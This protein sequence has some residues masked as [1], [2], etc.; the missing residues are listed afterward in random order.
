VRIGVFVAAALASSFLSAQ[1]PA[2]DLSVGDQAPPL[3]VSRWVKGERIERFEPGKV[4]VLDF[5]A[6]WCGPCIEAFPRLTRLQEKYA[7][8]GV[9]VV[10]VSIWEKDQPLVA[11]FVKARGDAMGFRVA[12]DDVPSG[13]AEAEE[14]GGAGRMAQAWMTAAGRNTIPAIFV[15][16]RDGKVAWIGGSN[17]VDEPLGRIVAG[18][19]RGGAPDKE[20]AVSAA[21]APVPA[22]RVAL[23]PVGPDRAPGDAAPVYRKAREEAK[24]RRPQ[25][26][27]ATAREWLRRPLRDFPVG[28]AR[29]LLGRWS[30]A[31]ER[32]EDGARRRTCEWNYPVPE[33]SEDHLKIQPTDAYELVGWGVLLALKARVEISEGRSEDA[34]HTIRSG[35]SFNQHLAAGQ[36]LTHPLVAAAGDQLM[37]DRVDELI[38]LQGAPNLYWALTALPRPLVDFRPAMEYESRLIERLVPELADLDRPRPAADWSSLLEKIGARMAV[39]RKSMGAVSSGKV[40]DGPPSA[41]VARLRAGLL[42]EARR[43]VEKLPEASRGRTG[44]LS[45]DQAIVLFIARWYRERWDDVFRAHHLPFPEA[46]P[47][48]AAAAARLRGEKAHVLSL[49]TELTPTVAR[50]HEVEA[51]LE[52]RVAALRAVEAVRLQAAANG[53]GMPASLDAVTLV[54]V[55][56]DPVTGRPFPYETDGKTATVVREGPA[57]SRLKV[58]YRIAPRG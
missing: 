26:A 46:R 49:L 9:V 3:R 42:P 14:P 32:I 47:F 36:F 23:L 12:L 16:G 8:K 29:A 27:F 15:V 10:G 6:T 39:I 18:T 31:L 57:P 45:D 13:G 56:P 38:T 22:L 21:P 28:E 53:G 52:R 1:L 43:F 4:Y 37:L 40:A 7:D 44:R 5:W 17:D 2:R 20:F 54:P 48:Y 24:T 35:L 30:E 33:R 58:A 41:G 51:E 55:P 34:L 11:P 50:F 25:E 19:W